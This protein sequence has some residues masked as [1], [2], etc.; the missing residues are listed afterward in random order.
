MQKEDEKIMQSTEE[1][2]LGKT[3]EKFP[4][5]V[6]HS[7]G[8]VGLAA[9]IDT[10]KDHFNEFEKL[11]TELLND[12]DYY[13]V[14]DKAGNTTKAIGKSGWYKFGVAFNISTYII[15]EESDNDF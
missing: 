11:K 7:S 1:A 15:K 3:G 2:E 13:D 9:K 10:I 12:N 14:K 4:L 5:V 8:I 6:E